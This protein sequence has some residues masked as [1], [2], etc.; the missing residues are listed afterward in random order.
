MD[1][2]DAADIIKQAWL[3]RTPSAPSREL[4]LTPCP[5]CGKSDRLDRLER[6][7]L[8]PGPKLEAAWETLAGPGRGVGLCGFC[9]NVVV[10]EGGSALAPGD[11]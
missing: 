8:G 5:Y 9:L 10:L 6:S 7:A 4:V 3:E 1:S 2:F 11:G